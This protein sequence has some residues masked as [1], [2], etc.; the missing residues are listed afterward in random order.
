[1]NVGKIIAP[2]QASFND[3]SLVLETTLLWR[4]RERERRDKHSWRQKTTGDRKDGQKND[5]EWTKVRN[6]RTVKQGN[7]VGKETTL[8]I[9][10][11]PDGYSSSKLWMSFLHLTNM[12]D[13]YVPSKRDRRGSLF[14]FLRFNMV[15]DANEL[16]QKVKRIRI[17]GAKIEANISKIARGK[18]NPSPPQPP[19]QQGGTQVHTSEPKTLQQPPQVRF[20]SNSFKDVVMVNA[21]GC[22]DRLS[23]NLNSKNVQGVE[24]RDGQTIGYDRVAWITIR[25]VPLHL[26]NSKT[27][28]HI[29]DNLGTVIHRST[30]DLNVD[31]SGRKRNRGFKVPKRNSRYRNQVRRPCSPE[32][33]HEDE[34]DSWVMDSFHNDWLVDS[35]EIEDTLLSD[36]VGNSLGIGLSHQEL[37]EET[38]ETIKIGAVVG[39]ALDGF[40]AQIEEAIRGEAVNKGI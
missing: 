37:M 1:M 5:K 26:W 34:D 13:A 27:F 30:A 6:R 21:S 2:S 19:K 14:G 9:S 28:D 24:F 11:L 40:E 17:G 22:N 32:Q 16:V 35:E 4:E 29:G 36:S 23:I 39:L 18:W 8:F 38:Q 7:Q 33:I 25:G 20:G 15:E 31:L 10:N 3:G 12:V